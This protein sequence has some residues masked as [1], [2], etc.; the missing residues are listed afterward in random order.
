MLCKLAMFLGLMI[1]AP[2]FSMQDCIANTQ[3]DDFI[4]KQMKE[5]QIPG[6]GLLVMDNGKI[7]KNQGYGFSNLELKT[8]VTPDS[9]FQ[10]ASAS[11]HFTALAIL[12]LYESGKIKSLYDP[13]EKYLGIQLSPEWKN[14]TVR[15]LLSHTSGIPNSPEGL[16]FQKDYTEDQLLRLIIKD[17]LDFPPG[18]KWMYSNGGYML[19]GIII[20]KVSGQ[21]YGDYLQEIAFKPLNMT[22]T[23]VNNISDIIPDRAAGYELIDDEVKNQNWVSPTLSRTSDGSIITTLNDMAK[24]NDALDTQKILDK[25]DYE[26]WWTPIKLNDRKTFPYGFAWFIGNVNGHKLIHHPGTFQGFRTEIARYPDDKLDV[27]VWINGNY[28]DPVFIAQ[29]AAGIYKPELT[30]KKHEVV[31]LDQA[32]LNKYAGT[33]KSDFPPVEVQ[34]QAA[35]NNQL[36]FTMG[37]AH[38]AFLPYNETSFFDPHSVSTLTFEIDKDQKTVALTLYRLEDMPLVFKRIEYPLIPRSLLFGNPEKTSAKIS[39]DGLKLAYLAPDPK[40][41]MNVWVRDLKQGGQPRQV[42]NDKRAIRQFIWQ[43]DNEHILYVQDKDGD[44]NWHLY[45]TGIAAKETKDLTPF[46]GVKAEILAVNPNFP[47]EILLKMNKRNPTFMD[48]YRLNLK[49]GKADLD[50]ENPG[51]VIRWVAD[52]DL[53]VRAALAYDKEGNLLVRVRDEKDSPWRVLLKIDSSEIAPDDIMGVIEFSADNQWLYLITSLGS[54]TANLLK[55]DVVTAHTNLIADDPQYDLTGILLNPTK[56]TLEAVEVDR[57]THDWIPISKKVKDDFEY[58]FQRHKGA[59]TIPSRDDDNQIW[60]IDAKSDIHPDQYNLYRR[61]PKSIDLLFSTQP[62]L[63]SYK[64]SPMQPIT[65]QA[66]DGLSLHGYLTLPLGSPPKN[67]PAVILVHG[68][69]WIRDSWEFNPTVQWLAN[70]GYA[71]LQINFRGSAGYGKAHLNA[72]NQEW[73]GKMHQ[74]ILDGRQWLIDKGYAN[75]AKIAIYGESYGGFETLAALSFSPEDFCCGIAVVGPS[76][77]M[78]FMQSL[79]TDWA[80]MQIAMERRIGKNPEFLKFRSP[81]F[82]AD[83]IKKPLLIAQGANDPRVKQAESDQIVAAI[84]KNRLPVQYLLFPDEGHS[85]VRPENRLKFFAAAEAF[86]TK[87]LGGRQEAPTQEENWQ[88]LE[89]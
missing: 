54:N 36:I 68:G 32:T 28:A 51:D 14:I 2:F 30:P 33:Y 37:D 70:R 63:D 82:K 25:D 77:L 56:Y 40:N 11:K 80:A 46:K 31:E 48:V 78:T 1:L 53:Q 19:L 79:P 4:E 50:T 65:F 81:L 73:A 59:F 5:Q 41:V 49:T 20:H 17:K 52:H 67:L 85:I 66:S 22:S 57:E 34:V 88:S 86:L 10:L 23:R 15:Q 12:K 8:P 60:V 29:Q 6:I 75:P 9:V 26:A 24:W 7:V 43:L 55:I 62:S 71:V 72:G 21:F 3:I 61:D 76:N 27:V 35:P 87:Y 89:H 74:D 64:M 47:E 69:P 45:Q 18:T 42:T 84:R 38:I 16:D 13:I 44:E 39:H 58:L 83:Q